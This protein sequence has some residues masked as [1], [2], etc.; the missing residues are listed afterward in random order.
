MKTTRVRTF[1]KNYSMQRSRAS[2]RRPQHQELWQS[3][4]NQFRD[5]KL[6]INFR[7]PKAWSRATWTAATW[8]RNPSTTRLRIKKPIVWFK[9]FW[10]GKFNRSHKIRHR[11][12]SWIYD[13]I[14][15]YLRLD[16]INQDVNDYLVQL[17][18]LLLGSISKLRS[19]IFLISMLWVYCCRSTSCSP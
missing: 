4:L 11:L 15:I 14:S 16:W 1:W 2:R 3:R 5:Y 17:L 6:N 12:Y 8:V 9:G 13:I 7:R 18:P 19:W 10:R